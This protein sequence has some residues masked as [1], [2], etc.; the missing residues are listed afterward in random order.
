MFFLRILKKDIMVENASGTQAGLHDSES[1][2]SFPAVMQRQR[3]RQK[4]R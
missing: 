3:R 4:D 2:C 1:G